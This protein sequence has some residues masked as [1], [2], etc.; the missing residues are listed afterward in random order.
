V[1]G[2]GMITFTGFVF[3]ILSLDVRCEHRVRAGQIIFSGEARS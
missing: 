2:G 3:S 1:L